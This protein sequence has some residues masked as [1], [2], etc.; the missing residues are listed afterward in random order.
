MIEKEIER[1]VDVKDFGVIL[2]F[3]ESKEFIERRFVKE[4]DIYWLI[5]WGKEVINF[6]MVSLDV[7]K[8]VIYVESG[9]VFIVEWVFKV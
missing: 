8:V 1:C 5:E 3:F 6:G 7:M 4:K 9:D 2:Y